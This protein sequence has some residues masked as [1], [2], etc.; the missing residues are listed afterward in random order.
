MSSMLLER[1]PLAWKRC[2]PYKCNDEHKPSAYA[3]VA[4][5]ASCLATLRCPEALTV[6]PINAPT[7]VA[8]S[9]VSAVVVLG[10]P[11]GHIKPSLSTPGLEPLRYVKPSTAVVEHQSR[12]GKLARL[13]A[14]TPQPSITGVQKAALP[15][16]QQAQGL[17]PSQ[18][19]PG[20]S[21]CLK[22]FLELS[23]RLACNV[24]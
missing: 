11:D 6:P 3:G 16:L 8:L 4:L 24:A 17:W 13:A 5:Y 21:L 9:S 7:Y 20:S 23:S 12:A 2:V 22:N 1:Q 15:P 14:P 18:G 10:R 19:S